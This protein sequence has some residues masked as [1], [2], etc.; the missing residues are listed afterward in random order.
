[1]LAHPFNLF[2]E[3]ILIIYVYWSHDSIKIA[4]Q[5]KISDDAL[6]PVSKV[7]SYASSSAIVV[8]DWSDGIVDDEVIQD[9]E[10]FGSISYYPPLASLCDNERENEN[11]DAGEHTNNQSSSCNSDEEGIDNAEGDVNIQVNVSVFPNDNCT[12]RGCADLIISHQPRS[13]N[14]SKLVHLHNSKERQNYKK[15]TVEN[16]IVLV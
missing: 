5:K 1:M 16:T 7:G 9:Y 8:I 12:C 13:V 10:S 4:T 14:K 3:M 15:L 6:K 2:C 11:P